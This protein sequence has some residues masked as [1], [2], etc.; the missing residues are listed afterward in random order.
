VR[1]ARLPARTVRRGRS[2]PLQRRSEGLGAS[3]RFRCTVP[4]SGCEGLPSEGST[5]GGPSR[6]RGCGSGGRGMSGVAASGQAAGGHRSGHRPGGPERHRDGCRLCQA[7][8]GRGSRSEDRSHQEQG[9]PGNDSRLCLFFRP[10]KDTDADVLIVYSPTELLE[11]L[12]SRSRKTANSMDAV[13]AAGLLCGLPVPS[14]PL[15]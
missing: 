7:R 6:F 12:T 8:P 1:A 4:A 15:R 2:L 11:I 13:R 3:R 10:R 14:T 5:A 9:A